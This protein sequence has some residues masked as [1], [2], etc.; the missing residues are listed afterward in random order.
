MVR[1]VGSVG[2]ISPK[3]IRVVEREKENG[4][5]SGSGVG[6]VEANGCFIALDAFGCRLTPFVSII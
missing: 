4:F 1:G 2:V 6:V 5:A 3:S